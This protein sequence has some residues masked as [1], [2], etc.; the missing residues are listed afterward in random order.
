MAFLQ[1]ELDDPN[2][3]LCGKCTN[4]L[5][6]TILPISASK[7]NIVEA[8]VFLKHSE[9]EI[10]PRKRITGS[11]FPIYGWNGTIQPDM[12][13]EI[14]RVLS[15][16]RDAG[17][18]KMLAQD[19]IIGRFREEL[20]QALYEMIIERWHPQPFPEWVTCI[21]SLSRPNLVPELARRLAE[22]LN[23]PLNQLL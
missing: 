16:W 22:K 5:N 8:S 21:P 14:G 17:W 20:V 23:V 19:K 18:G 10:Q 7:E 12:Q 13:A 1:E 3:I 9:F 15:R 6:R 11:P 4:C 2:I